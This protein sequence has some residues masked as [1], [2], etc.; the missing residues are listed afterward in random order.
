MFLVV[1]INTSTLQW[2]VYVYI[3]AYIGL[4]AAWV[5]VLNAS[6]LYK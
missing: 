5:V 1:G 3:Q 2:Q 6:S 4:D